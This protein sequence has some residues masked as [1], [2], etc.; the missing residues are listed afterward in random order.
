M[1]ISRKTAKR[2]VP[3]DVQLW[4][5]LGWGDRNS[6]GTPGLS[7]GPFSKRFDPLIDICSVL[8]RIFV[9]SSG[10]DEESPVTD[11]GKL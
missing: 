5:F 7:P 11:Q 2:M 6:I 4:D 10:F 3:I 8:Q 9:E 1:F